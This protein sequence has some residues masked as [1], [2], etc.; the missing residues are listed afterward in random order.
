MKTSPAAR[1][2][3]SG[4]ASVSADAMISFGTL[5]NYIGFY[6]RITQSLAFQAFVKQAGNTDIR[7]GYFAVL[8]LIGENP[9]ITQ[10]ALS[11]A[12]GRDKSSLTPVLDELA[13]RGL[14]NRVRIETNRR[15]NALNLTP[16]GEKARKKLLKS[17]D[18]H[19]HKL[20][21]ALGKEDSAE[22]LRMLK[23]LAASLTHRL[24]N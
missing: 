8:A 17:A 12:N 10:T 20:R 14:V 5:S 23:V 7:P 18:Q 11:H 13:R 6:L 19:E 24:S 15:A 2:K 22:F 3:K 21:Q 16:L 1:S 9:G 4:K